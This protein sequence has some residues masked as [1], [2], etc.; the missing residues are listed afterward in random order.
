MNSVENL[1]YLIA[2]KYVEYSLK[3]EY[4]PRINMQCFEKSRFYKVFLKMAEKAIEVKNF[5]VDIFVK[6][7]FEREENP[8]PHTFL[9]K[10]AWNFYYQ[11]LKR[12][13][14]ENKELDDMYRVLDTFEKIKLWSKGNGSNEEYDFFGYF[15]YLKETGLILSENP[16]PLICILSKDYWNFFPDYNKQIVDNNL[17]K[18]K[19]RKDLRKKIC[20]T[21][22]REKMID[23][24][25]F[26]GYHC[27]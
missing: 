2:K 18:L 1:A 20:Y 4:S 19:S 3:Y 9:S 5:N 25:D 15:K 14:K 26:I 17:L 16:S 27:P 6:A 21:M 23:N 24:L 11:I 10:E 12:G 7:Q 8:L 13:E 22:N